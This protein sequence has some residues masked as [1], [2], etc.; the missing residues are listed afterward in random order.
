MSC[1]ALRG[2]P[3]AK[4]RWSSLNC[5]GDTGDVMSGYGAIFVPR[6]AG[7]RSH[8]ILVP[9]EA[10][11]QFLPASAGSG[12][13]RQG[14]LLIIIEAHGNIVFSYK[15]WSFHNC[16]MVHYQRDESLTVCGHLAI[17]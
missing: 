3:R 8:H 13:I 12:L 11:T 4:S 1:D 17:G 15:N 9:R 10:F 6:E 16:G 2:A 5:T 14:L 7:E